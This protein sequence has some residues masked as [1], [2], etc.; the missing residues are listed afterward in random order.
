[1]GPLPRL[2]ALL[3]LSLVLLVPGGLPAAQ[4]GASN[5]ANLRDKYELCLFKDRDP[6][7]AA[8]FLKNGPEQAALRAADPESA[9]RI[10]ERATSLKDFSDLLVAHTN[11]ATMNEALRIRLFDDE[12]S[13]SAPKLLGFGAKP[14]T[15][16]EW[17]AKYFDYVSP[18]ALETAVWEWS[19]LA[20][21]QKAWLSAPPRALDEG[22]WKALSFMRR[23][24][25]MHEWGSE[26]YEKMMKSS[27]KTPEEL[28][29]I[30]RIRAQIWQVMDGGQKR[31]SGEFVGNAAAAVQ[32]L[33]GLP[34]SLLN[35]SDP[36]VKALLAQARSAST[37]EATLEALARLFD[38]S[39]QHDE[40]VATHAPDR[41][42]QKLSTVNPRI[43]GEMLGSG[44]RAEIKTVDAGRTVDEF[45]KDHPLKVQV[46]PLGTELAHFDPTDG[47]IVFNERFLTDWI[48]GQGLTARD[49]V[50]NPARLHELVMILAPVFVHEATHQMQKAW[51]DD[52]DLYA[53]NAQHQEIEAKEVQSDY[54]L[55]KQ[56]QS[57]AYRAF[58]GQA[59]KTSLYV[60][61]DVAQAA[62]FRRDP[63]MF[64]MA[65]MTDYY[66]G[67]PSLEATESARLEN[68]SIGLD[69]LRAE[70]ARRA[71]LPAGR[72]R[73]LEANGFTQDKDFNTMDE[74]KEYLTHV[75][76]SALDQMIAGLVR[77]RDKTLRTYELTSARE[78]QVL[79]RVESDAERV[80]RGDS[81]PS[82]R[83]VPPP[84]KPR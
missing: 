31:L 50:T 16:L 57:P 79:Q 28:D 25:R 37:P 62:A 18:K 42:D 61:Q 6:Y 2:P 80:I 12:T 73:A 35:S 39:G 53:W 15:L 30:Q 14:A 64:H 1:M 21:Y 58:L 71:S 68:I 56:A 60:Q 24:A 41:P 51:A 7:C 55:A 59:Q 40:T 45:Y 49:V 26:L 19:T 46:K 11:G 27:P 77:D 23:D 82:G 32:G 22:R 48:K 44:L 29:A 38:A 47:A 43:L 10:V 4:T 70:R 83:F 63:R 75:K 3:L 76:T 33:R 54:V 17:R 78:T 84:G 74:W 36:A 69:A 13:T 20:D 5:V 34:K 52:H 72:R 67:L 8:N 65:V 66:A 81:P 9:A